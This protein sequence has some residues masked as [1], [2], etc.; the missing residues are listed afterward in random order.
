MTGADCCATC[1]FYQTRD[2]DPVAAERARAAGHQVAEGECRR[3]PQTMRKL[4]G[5]G[6]GEHRPREGE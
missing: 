4:A 2:I 3:Y 1:R 5:E 6:C